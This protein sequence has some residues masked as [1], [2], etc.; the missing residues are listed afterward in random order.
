MMAVVTSSFCLRHSENND[1]QLTET[2]F[3]KGYKMTFQSEIVETDGIQLIN[4]SGRLDSATSNVFESSLQKLFENQ[5][6]LVTINFSGLDYISSAGL[7]VILMVAK[8][9]KQAKGRL[10]LFG[11]QPHVKEV[12]EISGFL[13]ILEVVNDQAE[14]QA[15]IKA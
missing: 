13:K 12:F 15:L 4:L 1:K 7:R 9:A 11:L 2:S 14:A 6:N 8:R 10:V 3:L 5:G